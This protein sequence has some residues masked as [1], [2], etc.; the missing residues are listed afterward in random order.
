VPRDIRN[1][2]LSQYHFVVAM[3]GSV[4]KE[5]LKIFPDFLREKLITWKIED[6]YG[7]DLS[8]YQSC[9]LKIVRELKHLSEKVRTEIQE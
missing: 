5:F 2:D 3:H 7:N 4:A 1:V 6:L 9:A 8:E